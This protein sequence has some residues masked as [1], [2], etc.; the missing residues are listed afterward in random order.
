[1]L[2][3]N[4]INT[5]NDPTPRHLRPSSPPPRRPKN[6]LP[7]DKPRQD[8]RPQT[9]RHPQE[10]L[11]PPRSRRSAPAP[12]P[13]SRL[14]HRKSTNFLPK[15]PS[16]TSFTT[17]TLGDTRPHKTTQAPILKPPPFFVVSL[18]SLKDKNSP[19]GRHHHQTPEV[20]ATDQRAPQATSHPAQRSPQAPIPR[21][22]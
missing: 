2:N 21:H 14:R 11:L 1:M 5:K 12:T 18:Q 10:L 13:E 9:P 19:G 15:P 6:H 7:L 16:A 22:S 4:K 20:K 17:G 3:P 8:H